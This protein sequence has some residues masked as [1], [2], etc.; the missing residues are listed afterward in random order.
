LNE[1]VNPQKTGYGILGAKAVAQRSLPLG[2]VPPPPPM[3]CC[4]K[5]GYAGEPATF[6]RTFGQVVSS[7]ALRPTLAEDEVVAADPSSS[8]AMQVYRG[9]GEERGFTSPVGVRVMSRCKSPTKGV[10]A[11]KDKAVE[12]SIGSSPDVLLVLSSKSLCFEDENVLDPAA[13]EANL[14]SQDPGNLKVSSIQVGEKVGDLSTTFILSEG[15]KSLVLPH[16]QGEWDKEM[17]TSVKRWPVTMGEDITKGK[18]SV[19]PLAVDFSFFQKPCTN[20]SVEEVW[21]G[22]NLNSEIV[23]KWVASKLKSIAGCIGV[24][25]TGHEMETIQLLSRIER[26]LVPALNSVQS[27]PSSSRRSRE[28]RRLEFGVNYDRS[29]TS[30]SGWKVSNG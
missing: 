4:P 25:F 5:C 13:F 14:S 24:A 23:S 28:L 2:A 7:E 17:E 22:E 18:E 26:S 8:L 29:A 15:N 3:G 12:Y 20:Y 1:I 27:S 10:R 30:T 11:G 19:E 16:N 21:D 9:R 6:L